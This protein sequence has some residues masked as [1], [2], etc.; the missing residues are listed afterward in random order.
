MAGSRGIQELAR[1]EQRVAQMDE[2]LV[3]GGSLFGQ[4]LTIGGGLLPEKHQASIAFH[5]RWT[6]GD[7]EL[8]SQRD[9]ALR[10]RRHAL[11]PLRE[12]FGLFPQKRGIEHRQRLQR[13]GRAAALG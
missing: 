6:S 3:G 2:R 8:K 10:Q 4:R 1:V 12:A 9:L 11:E 5:S 13:D 7:R